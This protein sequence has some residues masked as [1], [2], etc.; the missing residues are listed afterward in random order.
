M[1]PPGEL[2]NDSVLA[3]HFAMYR[4]YHVIFSLP[5]PIEQHRVPLNPRIPLQSDSAFNSNPLSACVTLMSLAAALHTGRVARC[6]V[7]HERRGRVRLRGKGGA[8]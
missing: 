5:G 3:A 6:G 4:Y 1:G 2:G 8:G 7:A